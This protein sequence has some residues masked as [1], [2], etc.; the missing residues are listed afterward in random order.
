M[1]KIRFLGNACIEIIGNQDHVIIDPVFLSAP[2]IGI[3][4]IFLTHHHSD[5]VN[6]EKLAEIRDKFSIEGNGPEIYGPSCVHEELTVDLILIGPDS[7]ITLNNG[8][9]EVFENECWKAPGCVAYLIEIDNKRILH[10]ADSANF[11]MQ[12]KDFKDKIDLCFVACFESN[13][14]DYLNFL[15]TVPS[16]ITIPY[17]FNHEKEDDAKKLTT[18][19]T[20]NGIKAKFLSIGLE[21]EL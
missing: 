16:D 5:H 12:L 1:P 20:N 7:K 21:Y 3:E 8:A 11:S 4:R 14:S 2:K 10:T 19:L 13:F 18:Y 9:V 17:H 6:Q 15:K